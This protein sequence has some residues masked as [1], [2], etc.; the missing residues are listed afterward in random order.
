VIRRAG[1]GRGDHQ[2]AIGSVVGTA[3]VLATILAIV[4]HGA[5]PPAAS[6]A[7]VWL[8]GKAASWLGR[9][10]LLTIVFAVLAILGYSLAELLRWMVFI[11]RT[12]RTRVAYAVLP[13]PDFDPRPEAIEAFGQQLLGARRR[14]LAWLDRP[15]CAIR[16]RLTTTQ[17]GRLLYLVELPARFRGSLLNAYATAYPAVEVR[18]LEEIA[19]PRPLP[20]AIAVVAR[21]ASPEA[22]KCGWLKRHARRWTRGI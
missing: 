8:L 10:T 14:V 1:S 16:I 18:P 5:H 2:A 12:L 7:P 15:A 4:A 21:R 19:T 6:V 13:P 17:D 9:W 22:E 20:S 3:V 11:P